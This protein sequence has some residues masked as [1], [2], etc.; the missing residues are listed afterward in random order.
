MTD[1]NTAG[2]AATIS[3][4]LPKPDPKQIDRKARLGAPSHLPPKQD[5]HGDPPRLASLPKGMA[6]GLN[7][8]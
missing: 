8:A 5:P 4:R 3:N 6:P 2:D 7:P 1:Q